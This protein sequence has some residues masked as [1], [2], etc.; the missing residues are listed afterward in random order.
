MQGL[1]RG[2]FLGAMLGGALGLGAGIAA[3]PSLVGLPTDVVPTHEPPR[4]PP[5]GQGSFGQAD[6]QDPRLWGAGGFSLYEGLLRLHDDF[7]V[8]PGPKYHLYLVPEPDIGRD[9]PVYDRMFIDLGPLRGF[10][11]RQDYP[12]P[13]GVDVRLYP[14]VVIWSEQFQGLVSPGPVRPL[15]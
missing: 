12:I 13:A 4:G 1:I 11:G 5:A 10:A 15:D 7:E 8:A 9:S 3:F 6:P 14:S 2:L